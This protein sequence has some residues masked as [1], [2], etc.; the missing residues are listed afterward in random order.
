[1]RTPWSRRKRAIIAAALALGP[2]LTGAAVPAGPATAAAER[3]D[4]ALR[5]EGFGACASGGRGG[6]VY[7]VSTLADSGQG[8]FRD[9][10]SQP[11]RTWRRAWRPT[12]PA[13]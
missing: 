10:V 13:A 5:G 2:A 3:R 8:S 12:P 6:A 1:M 7:H 9:A 11:H 4:R